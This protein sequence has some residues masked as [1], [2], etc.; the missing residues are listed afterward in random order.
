MSKRQTMPV[1]NGVLFI[2]V[3]EI[4]KHSNGVAL[5]QGSFCEIG[6]SVIQI[7]QESPATIKAIKVNGELYVRVI[8][9]EVELAFIPLPER[10][11]S[12]LVKH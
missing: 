8:C 9:N 4:I 7:P 2:P 6:N 12:I 3:T 5:R 11:S 10:I 1:G